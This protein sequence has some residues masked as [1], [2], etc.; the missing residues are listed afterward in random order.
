[1]TKR[2][3]SVCLRKKNKR[4]KDENEEEK[5]VIEKEMREERKKTRKADRE[6]EGI[7][8]QVSRL[9]PDWFEIVRGLWQ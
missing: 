2:R 8:G 7:G 5:R 1:M 9:I 4:K 3:E 6:S